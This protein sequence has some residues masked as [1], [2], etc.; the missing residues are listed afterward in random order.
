M[1]PVGIKI[2]Y[3][4][5]IGDL[6]L[7]VNVTQSI[8]AKIE[9]TQRAQ[10]RENELREA[11]AEA[12]KKIAQAEGDAKAQI[13]QAEGDATSTL[14]RAEAQAKANTVL[15]Q[16]ITPELVQ[17]NTVQTWDGKLPQVSGGSVPLINLGI[18]KD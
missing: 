7:P 15:A 8:N 5:F 6:R 13:A 18:G 14:M 12:E 9:A 10:Q 1:E 11:K 3:V 17:Y 2:D 16:S 4:S